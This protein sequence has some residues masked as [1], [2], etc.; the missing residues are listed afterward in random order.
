MDTKLQ[1]FER[2]QSISNEL[3]RVFCERYHKDFDLPSHERSTA[4][5]DWFMKPEIRSILWIL[6]VFTRKV[7][8]DDSQIALLSVTLSSCALSLIGLSPDAIEF[9]LPRTDE[10]EPWSQLPALSP[11]ET[12]F[13]AWQHLPV[14]LAFLTDPAVPLP[15][16]VISNPG[17]VSAPKAPASSS[18]HAPPPAS[19]PSSEPMST[20]L[21]CHILS[22]I[23]NLSRNPSVIVSLSKTGNP[24]TSSWLSRLVSVFHVPPRA[25]DHGITTI[26]RHLARCLARIFGSGFYCVE[27]AVVVSLQSCRVITTLVDALRLSSALP[28]I[29]CFEVCQL[30]VCLL[31]AA[32]GPV[33]NV[34]MSDFF[35]SDGYSALVKTLHVF[36]QTAS[37]DHQK[38]LIAYFVHLVFVERP[39]DPLGALTSPRL[40]LLF[41]YLRTRIPHVYCQLFQFLFVCRCGVE[42]HEALLFTCSRRSLRSSP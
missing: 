4:T 8:I 25:I 38:L 10:I 34:F 27:S 32:P 19:H 16:T 12:F 18:A 42:G 3:A 37:K 17:G 6:Q 31:R 23:G 22:I 2:D 14:G 5:L 1:R 26:Q 40:L 36:G 30:L 28:N 35:H 7:D 9:G 21:A 41:S 29:I 15:S 11:I 13:P 39:V 24:E 20:L 33:A